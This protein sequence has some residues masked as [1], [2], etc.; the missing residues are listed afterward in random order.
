MPTMGVS[1]P[2][3]LVV[4]GIT[5]IGILSAGY[6]GS[7]KDSSDTRDGRKD[8][9]TVMRMPIRTCSSIGT[10]EYFHLVE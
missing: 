6:V 10:L 3:H 7:S 9:S 4:F 1:T 2:Q 8:F 5:S